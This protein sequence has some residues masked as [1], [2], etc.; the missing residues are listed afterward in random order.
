MSNDNTL[1]ITGANVWCDD[2]FRLC[3]VV[4]SNGMI[5]ETAE[6]IDADKYPGCKV[7]DATGK[8]LVPG[9]VDMHV[10]F[11]EPGY[12]YKETIKDGSAAAAAGGFTTV[13]TMPNLNPAPDSPDNLRR[14][15]DI[16]NRDA[17]V[18][19]IPYATITRKRM[20]HEL[21]DYA[22]LAPY[23]AGF[24]DDGTGVQD[25]EVMRAAMKGIAP[26][27]KILAAHCEVEALLNRGY[28]HDGEYA[29]AH[30]H[31]GICSESE[32]KE[33]ERD[34]ILAEET[35]C[36]LHV[37]HISTKESV[38]LIRRAKERG[39]LVTCE[40]GPHYLT[41][42]DEDLQEEGRFKMNPPIRSRADRDALRQGII[43]GTIDAIATDH[44][45]HSAEEKGKG[46]EK[47]A[48]GVVGLETA[49]AAVY[50][51][52]VKTGLISME[53][54]VEIMSVNPRKILGLPCSDGIKAGN[55]AD[56]TIL[57]TETEQI[58]DPATFRT[59]GRATPYA[60]M[61]L[62][63]SIAALLYNGVQVL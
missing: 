36:R 20:G 57:D 49:F 6:K 52:M 31:R 5:V 59:K 32:W 63:G 43:D 13:C 10:H 37:C 53:R 48:M 50:T 41:F 26:T 11:R 34:I 51:T 35:H 9:L 14:Q 19:V 54:L 58:V 8:Y 55:P 42:C 28:I 1:L 45:P 25:E 16:I 18:N 46:L 3:D 40:T 29:R 33:I 12:S 39:V 27:G 2:S 30:G 22:T 60:G 44:A 17:I 15:L 4:V 47:S 24:S 56:I 23:V 62:Q 61:L 38:E 7:I 21:V